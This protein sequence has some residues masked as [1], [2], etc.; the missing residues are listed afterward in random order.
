MHY[1]VIVTSNVT[2]LKFV[3]QEQLQLIRQ[4]Y[5]W[6]WVLDVDNIHMQEVLEYYDLFVKS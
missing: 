5:I 3:W 2:W 6:D 1:D 4:Q